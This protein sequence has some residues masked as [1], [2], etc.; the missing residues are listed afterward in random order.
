MNPRALSAAMMVGI[1]SL[2]LCGAASAQN[3]RVAIR[4]GASDATLAAA[5]GGGR[6]VVSP[7]PDR[8]QQDPYAAPFLMRGVNLNNAVRF[9]TTNAPFSREGA[10]GVASTMMI[11]GAYRISNSFGVG[12]KLGV[13]RVSVSGA[14]TKWGFLNPQVSGMYLLRL[15]RGFRLAASLSASIPVG[16]G[17]GNS[18]D[19]DLVTAHK[20]AA[21]ARCAQENAMFGVND[22]TIGYGFDV[23]YVR[24]G[25]TAQLGVG[26]STG[27]RVRGDEVQSDTFKANST[28]G[29]GV[30]YFVMPQLSVGAE[31]RYQHYLSTPSSVEKD[32]SA[33]M[34]LAAAVG[35]RGHMKVGKVW[36]RPGASYG[37]G[38]VGPV[39]KSG[40]HLVQIDMPVVF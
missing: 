21:L 26:A 6:D 16:T 9:D 34:N 4:E 24:G 5:P 29:L 14:E 33:R 19:P 30:G 1:Q 20:A 10:P 38:I 22:M 40:Y 7:P 37:H 2:L 35:V 15:G 13:D 23:A 28:Y 3:K 32:P 8:A 27:F 17:G 18:G 25:F 39:E 31:L 36:M 11:A 12:V